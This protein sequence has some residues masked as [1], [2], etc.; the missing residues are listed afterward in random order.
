MRLFKKSER[1]KKNKNFLTS[2]KLVIPI[3]SIFMSLSV[4]LSISVVYAEAILHDASSIWG[5]SLYREIDLKDDLFPYDGSLNTPIPPGADS[6][7]AAAINTANANKIKSVSMDV[8]YGSRR[9]MIWYRG[10]LPYRQIRNADGEWLSSGDL[11]GLPSITDTSIENSY[12][13]NPNFG[14][15]S[16]VYRS[17]Y[18]GIYLQSN[19]TTA[20]NAKGTDLGELGDSN[21]NFKNRATVTK[22][23]NKDD[24]LDSV[25]IYANQMTRDQGFFDGLPYIFYNGQSWIGG[26]GL[27]LLNL[28]ISA[29]NIDM[30]VIM[31]TLKLDDLNEILTKTLLY[32]SDNASIS[33]FA[34]ICIIMLIFS[35]AAFAI[36]WARG[37]DKTTTIYEIVGAMII[38]AIL[39][40]TGIT[41]S[42]TGLGS[43]LSNLASKLM[44][45]GANSFSVTDTG[46]KA[47]YVDIN[48]STHENKIV[49]LSEMALVNK[50]YIDIQICSQ[51][52]VNSI[53]ALD[54]DN[55]GPNAKDNA[56]AYLA[57]LSDSNV[58]LKKDFNDNLGYYYWFANSPVKT[59]TPAN[60]TYP[61]TGASA[62][63]D[64]LNSMITFL[65]VQT[66]ELN[67]AGSS[68][69]DMKTIVTNLANPSAGFGFLR[70]FAF[71]VVM[72]MLLICTFKYAMNVLIA[73]LEMFVGLLGVPISG[74][75][76]L[77]R[78]N[79]LV[80]SGKA[81]L[82]LLLVSFLEMT[83]YSVV[84]D[85]ILF[86]VATVMGPTLQEC[87]ITL[88]LL[89]LLL[90]FNPV[91]QAKLKSMLDS[92]SRKFCPA[93]V[94]AK[95][96]IKNYARQKNADAMRAYNQ[97][98]K[99]VYDDDGNV[100]GEKSRN[101]NALSRMWAMGTEAAF[102]ESPTD[103]K[104][105]LKINREMN[106][107][108][109]KE[110]EDLAN[111]EMTLL[112]K[113]LG[114]LNENEEAAKRE[115]DKLSRDI[116]AIV[117]DAT[118]D[119]A[120]VNINGKV[121]DVNRAMLT[122]EEAKQAE[123]L[124]TL[125]EKAKDLDKELNSLE[126][127]SDFKS[128]QRERAY[129]DEWNAMNP[130]NKKS[131]SAD[132]EAKLIAFEQ[133]RKQ[134][135]EDIS[136]TKLTR[137]QLLEQ[138]INDAKE[139][140]ETETIHKETF[141]INGMEV[142]NFGE[143][144]DRASGATH[145]EKLKNAAKLVYQDRHHDEIE[146]KLNR[147]LELQ[148]EKDKR[149]KTGKIGSKATTVDAKEVQ[150]Q[151][152]LELQKKRLE[153]GILIGTLEEASKSV[154]PLLRQT[155]TAINKNYAKLEKDSEL[156]Q[157]ISSLNAEIKAAKSAGDSERMKA[158]ETALKEAEKRQKQLKSSE[159]TLR[160]EQLKLAAH[161][162]N[163]ERFFLNKTITA[164][165][166]E[167][168]ASAI[169]NAELTADGKIN[170]DKSAGGVRESE[171]AAG[172]AAIL[173]E[174]TS[175]T[176]TTAPKEKV[177]S[178]SY[179]E[180]FTKSDAE[181]G[182]K[183]ILDDS[184]KSKVELNKPAE[185]KEPAY[186]EKQDIEKTSTE[187]KSSASTNKAKTEPPKPVNTQ[188]SGSNSK[189]SASPVKESPK[190]SEPVKTTK[191]VE[192]KPSQTVEQTI[193]RVEET[194][195]EQ[196]KAESTSAPVV[197]ERKS[198]IRLKTNESS[199]P[200]KQESNSSTEQRSVRE[201]ISDHY[202]AKADK[203][204][205]KSIKTNAART[206]AESKYSQ[207]QADLKSA[208]TR[209]ERK[210]AAKELKSARKDL[211]KAN[212][213]DSKAQN[214]VE[215]THR[216]EN[217]V[218]T[219]LRTKDKPSDRKE[220]K[221]DSHRETVTYTEDKDLGSIIEEKSSKSR[222]AEEY[223]DTTVDYDDNKSFDDLMPSE[224]DLNEGDSKR[225][226][227]G[228]KK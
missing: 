174:N 147:A 58:T 78:H 51:F 180:Q 11:E 75:M 172:A 148:K 68:V 93:L 153:Q 190:S 22:L 196:P 208:T 199:A 36:K 7:A 79:K 133:R 223:Q 120:V 149:V 162:A 178:K 41:G 138:V 131:L 59:K 186:D 167:I 3:L 89:W 140:I 63:T 38:G 10:E 136:A 152:A 55:L 49:Q 76:I 83:V 142:K 100:I 179:V 15:S 70:M 185:E 35:I 102:N 20:K 105:F 207:A 88:A 156:Q 28:V 74:P 32:D 192:T 126:N 113:S 146:K 211:A 91:I 67:S 17:Q 135:S 119:L 24:A 1:S 109:K 216:D 205:E 184:K 217:V 19:N 143:Y 212:H 92:T 188:S 77:S 177:M 191:P 203:A 66:N 29:K 118:S 116:D 200:V 33:P 164:N 204:R 165:E 2:K 13:E 95:R 154:E 103:R 182:A 189:P 48:D 115:A 62:T 53:S 187:R 111:K 159:K 124:D 198:N 6:S 14:A 97:S 129:I 226:L 171:V 72:I 21:A 176:S 16:T 197:E 175:K 50:T 214:K 69:N 65:Q 108:N 228:K 110:K 31:D 80:S 183:A 201:S 137:E 145:D 139:R 5:G 12:K 39:I 106:K 210:E 163:D 73:K 44:Y 213:K 87:L 25:R 127:N 219:I 117:D 170:M 202:E 18:W 27:K 125:A 60:K 23:V 215:K 151:M 84:F 157:E 166:D 104:G 42:I 43:N 57:G 150:K 206:E 168:I 225:R 132:D 47:F 224:D 86:V 144:Y 194:K 4:L 54:F 169:K 193:K 9:P 34:G 26:L 227:F 82:G 30:D 181:A 134:L 121:T 128:L 94:G 195:V 40:G 209:K 85:I 218:K 123:E 45:A 141:E 160:K 52:G 71:T 101:G 96:S 37:S 64:K 222:Y 220:S 130:E 122:A 81:I 112:D 98:T 161:D 155:S 90:K 56:K 107:E 61:T 114:E 158:A 8:L 221:S 99:K 46:K 173:G